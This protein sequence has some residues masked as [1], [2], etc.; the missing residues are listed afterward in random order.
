MRRA[1]VMEPDQYEVRVWKCPSDEDGLIPERATE[2]TVYVASN[3]VSARRYARNLVARGGT[4]FGE[5]RIYR[6]TLDDY[7][8]WFE[9]ESFG[10]GGYELVVVSRRPR[11]ATSSSSA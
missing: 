5:A 11:Y 8:R 7:G 2:E 6:E 3:V 10:D 9:D 1:V 4:D